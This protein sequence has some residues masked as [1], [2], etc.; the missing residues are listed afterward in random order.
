M[1][2]SRHAEG[3]YSAVATFSGHSDAVSRHVPIGKADMITLEHYNEFSLFWGYE[4]VTHNN[5][6][7]EA[8][9]LMRKLELDRSLF[10]PWPPPPS[11]EDSTPC[12]CS[13]KKAR[14]VSVDSCNLLL[15]V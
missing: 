12:F 10:G 13:R 6:W 15:L 11:E 5:N 9:I 8:L 2:A 14:Q 1:S 4:E 7:F 3:S